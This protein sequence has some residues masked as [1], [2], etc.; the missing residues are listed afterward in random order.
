[1]Y[2]LLRI[3][4][5]RPAST[6]SFNPS[7]APSTLQSDS[8]AANRHHLVLITVREV[9]RRSGIPGDWIECQTLMV[10]SRRRG[11]GLYIQ[12]VVN[13]WDERLLRYACALQAEIIACI[14][15]FDPKAAQWIHAVSWQFPP[16]SGCPFTTLPEKSYWQH[17]AVSAQGTTPDPSKPSAHFPAVLAVPP[18]ADH[19]GPAAATANLQAIPPLSRD[20]IAQDLEKLFAIRDEALKHSGKNA[21]LQ[22]G[23]EPTEPSPLNR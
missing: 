19:T 16:N 3:L 8:E 10:N 6:S 9:W 13:H 14:Q 7:V 2:S 15:R 20:E 1:M 23:F 5:G 4:F 11:S 21:S 22:V 12:L 17:A 18:A